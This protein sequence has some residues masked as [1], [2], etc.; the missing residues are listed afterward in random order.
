MPILVVFGMIAAGAAI[1]WSYR[2]RDRWR[3]ALGEIADRFGLTYQQGGMW[4]APRS[5]GVWQGIPVKVDTFTQSTGKSSTTYTRVQVETE[6]PS[7]FRLQPEGLG[8]SFTKTFVGE[9]F[10]LGDAAFDASILVRAPGREALVWLGPD[11]RRAILAAVSGMGA[12]FKDGTLTFHKVG[13]VSDPERLANYTQTLLD[14]ARALAS[15]GRPAQQRLLSNVW[16]DRNP[17]YRRKCVDALLEAGRGGRMGAEV[18]AHMLHDPALRLV[19]ASGAGADGWDTLR[20]LATDTSVDGW[21]RSKALRRALAIGPP[22]G[23]RQLIEQVVEGGVGDPL[24]AALEAANNMRFAPPLA[25]LRAAAQRGDAAIA[26]AVAASLGY[27]R[28]PGAPPLLVSMLA[29]EHSDTQLAICG[30]L[31]QVGGRAEVEHLLP[32][33]KGLF[34]DGGLK[35]AARDA[36]ATI[37]S[38]LAGA[39]AGHLSI[40]DGV[41]DSGALSVREHEGGLSEVE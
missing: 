26:A 24:A 33:T 13:Y 22:D 36:V 29:T 34:A 23:T 1:A 25:S 17:G 14:A 37:Q 6:L 16:Q 39:G 10:Q 15:D 38:R 12:R 32:L 5:E 19:S 4:Q 40:D 30:A 3:G 11:A 31:G 18:P 8:T 27:S 2:V 21:I 20:A 35:R 7:S 9:D 41:Q 28:D